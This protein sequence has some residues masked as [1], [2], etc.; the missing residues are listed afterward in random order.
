MG[1]CH[2]G[3]A[4]LADGLT[5]NDVN[6]CSEQMETRR[7]SSVHGE[8]DEGDVQERRSQSSRVSSGSVASV[9]HLE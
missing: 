6:L 5:D 9:G 3:P 7:A 2:L 8:L 1:S 4:A